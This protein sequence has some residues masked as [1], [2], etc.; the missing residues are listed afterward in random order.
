MEAIA[1]DAAMVLEAGMV[2]SINSSPPIEGGVGLV[3]E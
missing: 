1:L 2:R 3:A